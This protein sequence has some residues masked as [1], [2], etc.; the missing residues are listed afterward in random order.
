MSAQIIDGKKI[1]AEIQAEIKQQTQELK[2]RGTVPGLGV[3]LVGEDPA[4][5]VYVRNKEKACSEVGIYTETFRLPEATPEQEILSQI[6]QWNE[7][8]KIHGIL[9]Q[10]PLPAHIDEHKVIEA[11]SL[12]KDVDCFHPYN[13]GKLMLGEP[14]FLPC[15]PAGVQEL[16]VRTGIEIKGKYIVIV[17]RSNI[18]GKPLANILFQKAKNANA[19]VTIC[20]TGTKDLTFHTR[21]A[22]IL[23][24][25]AGNPQTIKGEMLKSGVV[26]VDVGVNRIKDETT[27]SGYRLVGDVEFDSAKEVASHITP[28]PGGVGPMTITMLLK[29]TV[30]A[31]TQSIRG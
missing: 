1:A 7:D 30:K 19:T 6:S 26:V 2:D 10:L 4:S 25:A 9:V 28:V 15:T 21:Q 13:V 8:K 29:N 17:G 27:K 11:I 12:S 24:A 31:A 23:V 16:L 20:H 14:F 22:D 18:V 3:I 5:Q